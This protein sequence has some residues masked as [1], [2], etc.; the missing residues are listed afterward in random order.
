MMRGLRSFLSIAAFLVAGGAVALQAATDSKNAKP[1]T[2]VRVVQSSEER[3]EAL[4]ERAPVAFGAERAP[5]LTITVNEAVGYQTI[6]G[7]GAS[8]T[9]SSAWLLWNKLSEAQ[10]KE[11]L[12]KLFD[13]EKGI[14]LSLLRQPM[15]SSD[16]ATEDYSYD[17][18]P[19]GE[20]DPELKKFSIAKDERYIVPLLREALAL[21]PQLRVIATPWSPPGWMKTSGSMIQGALLP[22]AYKPLAAYFVKF[23]QA[24]ERAGVPIYAITPQNEPHFVPNNYPGIH[25][26]PVELRFARAIVEGV[27]GRAPQAGRAG[28]R[29]VVGENRRLPAIELGKQPLAE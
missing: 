29:L 2:Q 5:E 25:L 4:E 22:E 17:D 9:D 6:D 19:S 7:F 16:F 3:G 14:G 11:T 27:R 23:V 8:L 10:R 21:N 24:Y 12:Q 20:R 15:G 28:E 18:M 13:P 1:A 26:E